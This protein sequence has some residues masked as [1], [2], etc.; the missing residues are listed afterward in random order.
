[1]QRAPIW[2][3]QSANHQKPP[4]KKAPIST[5]HCGDGVEQASKER[6]GRLKR[7]NCREL[8]ATPISPLFPIL[9]PP[10]LPLFNGTNSRCATR[11]QSKL[12]PSQS[13]WG[14][15][16]AA[17]ENARQVLLGTL[18]RHKI[19]AWSDEPGRATT[20][21][22]YTGRSVEPGLKKNK[23]KK[24]RGCPYWPHTARHGRMHPHCASGSIIQPT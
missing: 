8:A 9:F 23:Q 2:S 5:K 17:V 20:A 11:S 22:S 21:L 24:A 19:K 7:Y 1:M 14:R 12:P 18:L 6:W 16:V 15:F 13:G 4:P 10:P 3:Q